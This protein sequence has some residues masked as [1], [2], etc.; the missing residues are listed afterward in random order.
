[1]KRCPKCFESAVMQ[2]WNFCPRCGAELVDDKSIGFP[3]LILEECKD[4]EIV[5]FQ[6]KKAAKLTNLSDGGE[7]KKDG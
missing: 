5:L 1:M 4:N 6:G 7:G 2:L 3:I